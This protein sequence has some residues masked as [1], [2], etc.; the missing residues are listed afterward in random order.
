MAQ[1]FGQTAAQDGHAMAPNQTQF[2]LSRRIAPLH[3][4]DIDAEP[5]KLR[6]SNVEIAAPGARGT[7]ML[8]APVD[9]IPETKRAPAIVAQDAR[10]VETGE[11][12]YEGTIKRNRELHEKLSAIEQR[13]VHWEARAR[14]ERAAVFVVFS[15]R[16]LAARARARARVSR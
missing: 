1:Q 11:E 3:E 16:A 4:A 12:L 15:R 9:T 10:L 8:K 13:G 6:A 14:A 5:L 7:V 2:T